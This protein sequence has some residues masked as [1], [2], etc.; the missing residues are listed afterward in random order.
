MNAD[1][2]TCRKLADLI[3]EYL[4]LMLPEADRLRLEQHLHECI[5]CQV[6][7]SQVQQTIQ[8]I[9]QTSQ[10]TVANAE[11]QRLLQLFRSWQAEP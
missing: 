3:T 11:R 9:R 7:L 8:I 10:A 6:H 2:M 4:E 1:D 5:D